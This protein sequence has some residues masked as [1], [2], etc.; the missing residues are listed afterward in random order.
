MPFIIIYS[1]TYY[2]GNRISRETY[3]RV[4]QIRL[5]RIFVGPH[6]ASNI[7][8]IGLSEFLNYRHISLVH[9]IF[10]TYNLSRIPAGEKPRTLSLGD[11]EVCAI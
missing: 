4:L 7:V 2:I 1:Q 9:T 8:N 6:Q 10:G 3:T 11:Q 5:T